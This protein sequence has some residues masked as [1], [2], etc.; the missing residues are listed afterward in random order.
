M[1]VSLFIGSIIWGT[2]AAQFLVQ[3]LSSFTSACIYLYGLLFS[4]VK[5]RLNAIF[6]ITSLTQAV[7]FAVLLAG[8]FWL[9]DLYIPYPSNADLIAAL[10]AF[11]FYF[12]NCLVQVPDKILVARMCAMQPFFAE[13]ARAQGMKAALKAWR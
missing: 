3:T 11:V 7:V 4:Q 13:F 12:V 2:L 1:S 5:K 10:V 9:I 6:F 8:G